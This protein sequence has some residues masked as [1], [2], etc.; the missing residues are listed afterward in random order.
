MVVL[1]F[2]NIEYEKY[3][4]VLLLNFPRGAILDFMTSYGSRIC[5]GWKK[6]VNTYVDA[7]FKMEWTHIWHCICGTHLLQLK[8]AATAESNAVKEI[9][10]SKPGM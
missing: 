9:G 5:F 4:P 1:V 8:D 2:Q 10:H 3:C 6:K 7:R